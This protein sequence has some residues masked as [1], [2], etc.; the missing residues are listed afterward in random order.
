MMVT[1]ALYLY[2][3]TAIVLDHAHL[4]SPIYLAWSN[5]GFRQHMLTRPEK[6][7][8]LPALCVFVAMMIGLESTTTREPVFRALAV[9][10]LWW[11]AYHFGAQHFGIAAL[12]GWRSSPRWVRQLILIPPTMFIM[13]VPI[14]GIAM[15]VIGAAISLAHWLTSIGLT[16]WATRHRRMLFLVGVLCVGCVG[17]VWK[18]VVSEPRLCGALPTCTAMWSIP[19]LLGLRFGLGF[20]HFLYDRWVWKL[21]DPHVRATIGKELFA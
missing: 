2:F 16:A 9:V 15:A 21:S 8:L 1:S 7:I 5:R 6:F 12:A 4:V 19:S 17:F 13:L 11:N 3:L 20:V 10:Y 14:G 18:A